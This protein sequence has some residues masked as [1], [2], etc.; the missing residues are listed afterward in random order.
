M[1]ALM[2]E[3]VLN[4]LSTPKKLSMR[5]E[6]ESAEQRAKSSGSLTLAM[7]TSSESSSSICEGGRVSAALN[8]N[9]DV[10]VAETM[11]DT[12]TIQRQLVDSELTD[13]SC[14]WNLESHDV[15]DCEVE[16]CLQCYWHT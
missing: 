4:T 11:L 2:D 1:M 5:A 7:M 3:Q 14:P 15:A 9:F 10:D 6:A 12:I 8:M 16:D 13:R